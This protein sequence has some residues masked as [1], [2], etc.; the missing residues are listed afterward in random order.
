LLTRRR[1]KNWKII[2]LLENHLP[3]Q[4]ISS[5]ISPFEQIK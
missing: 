4:V 1:A 3:K 5:H 2:Q